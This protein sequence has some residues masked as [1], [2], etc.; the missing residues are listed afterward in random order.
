MDDIMEKLIVPILKEKKEYYEMYFSS[1]LQEKR[2]MAIEKIRKH[3]I[4]K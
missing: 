4:K 3:M 2:R 1:A